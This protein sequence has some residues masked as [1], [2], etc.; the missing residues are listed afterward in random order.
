[1]KSS[2]R[3][4]RARTSSRPVTCVLATTWT[5]VPNR[6]ASMPAMV[7]YIM[8]QM[9]YTPHEDLSWANK[10]TRKLGVFGRKFE[11]SHS[12]FYCNFDKWEN[13]ESETFCAP[14]QEEVKPLCPPFKGW[15]LFVPPFFCR[16]K[17][18]LASQLPL[19][20]PSPPCN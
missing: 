7:E 17:T 11:G 12:P 4:S 14:P 2:S 13:R 3:A 15:K 16:G 5:T 19:C 1:M 9:C 10:N 8:M 6:C 20:S 18:S